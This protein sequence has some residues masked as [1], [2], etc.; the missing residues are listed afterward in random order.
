MSLCS[1]APCYFGSG[2]SLLMFLKHVYCRG[3][4]DVFRQI[5]ILGVPRCNPKSGA[6]TGWFGNI[7]TS[8]GFSFL[9]YPDLLAYIKFSFLKHVSVGRTAACSMFTVKMSI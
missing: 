6:L 3:S 9:F 2:I 1:Q 8:F 7:F 4:S 5:T